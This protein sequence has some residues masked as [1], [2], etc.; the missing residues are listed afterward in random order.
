MLGDSSFPVVQSSKPSQIWVRF[1]HT[2][3]R[4]SHWKATCMSLDPVMLGQP[5]VRA[6]HNKYEAI[7]I[8]E[9]IIIITL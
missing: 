8:I 1:R 2:H 5:T 3:T 7:G 9:K 6:L 4:V